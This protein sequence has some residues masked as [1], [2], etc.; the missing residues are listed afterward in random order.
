M[1]IS[2]FILLLLFN[3]QKALA[4]ISI[5]ACEP[6]W[7]AL[8]REIVGRKAEVLLGTSPLENPANVRVNNNLLNVVRRADLIFC[9]GGG[10]EAKWLK[11]AI[12]E[13]NNISARTN[14]N[15]LLLVYGENIDRQKIIPRPHLNPH[16][17]LPIA[18]ELTKRLKILDGLN[19]DFY[20]K[21]Y[22]AFVV[23]WKKSIELWEKAAA[24]LKGMRVVISNDSWLELTKWLG[25]EVAAKIDA[26]KSYLENNQ[27]LNEIVL[28]LREKPAKAIIFANYEDK[29][30]ILWLSEKTKTRVIL[31]PF[32]VGGTANSAN[33]YQFFATTINLLL[34]DCTK[35]LCPRL[36]IQ[37]EIKR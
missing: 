20:Q 24:P 25:L 2:I 12:E 37:Q 28:S 22:E 35:S 21:S 17:I 13:G 5:Y 4:E 14:P 19:E 9:T 7:A 11:R 26:K 30:P 34:V 33:L 16:N 29:K 3:A 31:L 23:K 27:R 32:T 18:A 8:T 10:L 6:E 1:R 36:Q 15:A